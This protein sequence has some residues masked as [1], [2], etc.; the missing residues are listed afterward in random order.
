MVSTKNKITTS[1]NFTYVEHDIISKKAEALHISR[2]AF[3]RSVLFP[4]IEKNEAK[5]NAKK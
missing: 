4:R 2:S 3:I 1:I 5:N